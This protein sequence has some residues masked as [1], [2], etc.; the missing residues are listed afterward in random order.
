VVEPS[1]G[2]QLWDLTMLYD[3][4]R[5][6]DYLNTKLQGQQKLISEV[7]SVARVFK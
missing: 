4:S 3:I 7:V 5:H 2:S 6:L 1:S